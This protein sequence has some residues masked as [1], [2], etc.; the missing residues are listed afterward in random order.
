MSNVN[1]MLRLLVHL[2]FFLFNLFHILLLFL[3][4]SFFIVI[5]VLRC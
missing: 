1:A 2:L 4:G 5:K 3:L